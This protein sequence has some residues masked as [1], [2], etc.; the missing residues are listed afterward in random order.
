MISYASNFE[1]VLLNRCFRETAGG[2]YVDIGAGHPTHA[3]VT[4]A[5]YD[6]GWSGINVEPGK[7]IE[8]LRAE[9][10]RD[11]NVEGAISDNDG[12]AEFWIHSGNPGTSS[13]VRET[14][15]LVAAKAGA[16]MSKTVRVT[17]LAALLDEH[18]REQH[19]HFLK[20]DAEGA[21]G[22]II[23]GNNWTR[24]RPEVIVVE[25]TEPYTNKRRIETWQDRLSAV[26]FNLAYFDGINDFWVRAESS[27]LLGEFKIPVNLLDEFTI[28]NSE[29]H[30][31]RHAAEERLK[32]LK[33]AR[34]RIQSLTAELN[35]AKTSAARARPR[36]LTRLKASFRKR[37]RPS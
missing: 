37:L 5:F 15:P 24:Y 29:L 4:R 1:D 11:I 31:L 16:I 21:E 6:R 34:A 19:I 18:A 3:S 9:R 12:S 13:L 30:S 33:A 32:N 20:I 7:D 27:H 36:L 26:E 17:T 14:T 8:S 25:S 10:S 22:A 23:L 35:L 2:F 28:Y